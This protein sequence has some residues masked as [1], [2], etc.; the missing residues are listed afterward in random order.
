MIISWISGL[1]RHRAGR[2]IATAAGIALAVAL[3]ASLGSFLTASKSTM[4]DR[5]VTSVAVDWQVE[6]QPGTDPVAVLRTVRA[7]PG[8]HNA[9]RVGL[10]HSTGFEATGKGSTQNTGPGVVLGLSDTY[11]AAFPREIRQLSGATSG[12]LIA[13]QTAANLHVAPGDTVTV[14][15]PGTQPAAVKVAGVVDLPQADSLFQKVGA[16]PQSQPTAPPDNVLLLPSPMFDKLTAPARAVDPA[17]VTTQ[18]HLNRNTPLPTDPAAAFTSVTAAAHNLEARTSG[19][20]IV[21]DNLGAALDAARQDALYA[22]ILF[23]FLGVPGAV[24]AALLTAAVAGAGAGRRRREQALLRTRGLR[25]RQVASMAGGEAAVVG[26][27]GGLLGLGI[28]ALVGQA[29]FGTAS[30]GAR[31]A[32]AVGWFA[33]AL[34]FGLVVAAGAVLIPALRDLRH[35]T[36]ATA[37]QVVGR[38]RAPWWMRFG[39]DFILLAAS[40]LVFRASSGNQYALVL[41]PEGVASISVSYWAFLGPALLWF[42]GALLLWRLATLVLA[43]G[44]RSLARLARPLTGALAGTTAASMSRQRRPLARAIVL[45]ALAVSFAAS[46]ATFNATYKQQAQVDAQLTNGADVTVTQSPGVSVGRDA[47]R[48]LKVAGVR[49]VEPVQHR[50]AYVGADLQDLY[51]VNPASIASATSLQDAYFAGGTAKSL[52]SKLSARP[53]SVLVSEET[54]KDFQLSPGDTLN[55][56]LQDS[57]TKSLRTVAFHYAGI[58][59]EFPTAPKDSFFVANADYIAKATASVAVGTFLVDTGGVHQK[60]VAATLRHQLG[61]TATVTDVVGTRSTVG[62]SLT[63]VDLTGLTRIELGF[64]VL[65]AAASGGIVLALGLAERRRTFA[66]TTVL[67]ATRR[68][69]RGLVLSEAAVMTAGGLAGGAL[70]GWALSE[71][72]VKVLTGVFDPP[73]ATIAVPW[74]YLTLTVLAAVA[75]IAAAALNAARLSSRPAVEELRE[76]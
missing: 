7:T 14:R 76:L 16:P 23:L 66:I 32:S 61:T 35:G 75:A 26:V 36:V 4:T 52:M 29:A 57:R 47:G 9:Q 68:Q 25:P 28:A 37:R 69:L 17:A 46:T 3:V 19:G 67:G 44:R 11:R 51:G 27:A 65:L 70:I 24:L 48:S 8:V 41:A 30:F 20:A 72:L 71:M 15:L 34:V 55:L 33:V 12:A 63:S 59:K 50:F 31:G 39:V 60:S 49:H 18:I 10:A 6:V 22:Q 43:H 2:L 54:V 42:G 62:S 53:D 13:Q 73:P 74:S 5:A 45:L 1:L 64:A 58:V 21:G 56:R 40:L 38:A